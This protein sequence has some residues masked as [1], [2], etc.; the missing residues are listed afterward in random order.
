MKILLVNPNITVAITDVMIA[1][2][3]RVAAPSTEVEI[4]RAS[5]RERVYGSV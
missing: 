1:E 3:R 2:A 5:C 4:G